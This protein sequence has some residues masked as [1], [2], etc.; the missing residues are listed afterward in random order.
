VAATAMV[1]LVQT[2]LE[3][4]ALA[5]AAL[6]KTGSHPRPR[7]SNLRLNLNPSTTTFSTDQPASAQPAPFP[8]NAKRPPDYYPIQG[9]LISPQKWFSLCQIF[10]EKKCGEIYFLD[11]PPPRSTSKENT[12]HAQTL[13]RQTRDDNGREG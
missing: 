11:L 9:F 6:K 10:G 12:N 13:L 8:Q 1:V 3:G 2:A 5:A 7:T 4:L